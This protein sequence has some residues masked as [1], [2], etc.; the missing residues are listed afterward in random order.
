M[1]LHRLA[2]LASGIVVGVGRLG[3]GALC[4]GHV[5][6]V[7]ANARPRRRATA[8]RVDQDVGRLE[9][10][11]GFRVPRLPP[12][13]AGERLVLL[14]R[15]RDDDQWVRLAAVEAA[16]DAGCAPRDVTVTLAATN[17]AGRNACT[18]SPCEVSA[19]VLAPLEGGSTERWVPENFWENDHTLCVTR[20]NSGVRGQSCKPIP[21]QGG[22]SCAP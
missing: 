13:Q 18:T 14:R 8:H 9:L 17:G 6:Q 16:G 21:S 12:R 15:V 2:P 20:S 1:L 19:L 5:A 22:E 10:R 11:R 4:F 7:D 3:R